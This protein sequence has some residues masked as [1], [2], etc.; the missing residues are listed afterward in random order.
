MISE[1][2][3]VFRALANSCIAVLISSI[4]VRIICLKSQWPDA[5]P[6]SLALPVSRASAGGL[7]RA[8]LWHCWLSCIHS[9][10]AQAGPAGLIVH[11]VV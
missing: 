3:A 4:R 1:H 6:E 2:A 7:R 11:G 9:A 10:Q 8:L 5:L